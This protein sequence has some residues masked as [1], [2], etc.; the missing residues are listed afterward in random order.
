MIRN[1]CEERAKNNQEVGPPHRLR[2]EEKTP[3]RGSDIRLRAFK[4]D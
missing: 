4:R 3:A 1:G 2:A